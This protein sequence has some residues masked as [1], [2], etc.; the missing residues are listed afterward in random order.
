MF[1]DRV[2]STLSLLYIAKCVIAQLHS[3][4]IYA[5]LPVVGALS[6]SVQLSRHLLSHTLKLTGETG[7]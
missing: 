2:V 6:L 7:R 4:I 3:V 1:R 5:I